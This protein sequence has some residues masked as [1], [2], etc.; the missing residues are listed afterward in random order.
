MLDGSDAPAG[1]NSEQAI[2]GITA[3]AGD[4]IRLSVWIKASDL[5]P[6][7]AALYPGTWAVGF[8]PAVLHGDRQQRSGISNVGPGPDLMCVFPK[9]TQF[10]W[11]QYTLDVRCRRAWVQR[12]WKSASTFIHGSRERSTSTI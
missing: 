12:R 1:R 3:R 7:S 10:D 8:T 11:T 2:S 9:V 5:V 4:I 6:D